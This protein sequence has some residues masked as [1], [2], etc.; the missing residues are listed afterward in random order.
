MTAFGTSPCRLL[1]E[2]QRSLQPRSAQRSSRLGQR[3]IDSP[4]AFRDLPKRRCSNSTGPAEHRGLAMLA[5]VDSSVRSRGL[6]K[7]LSHPVVHNAAHFPV[8]SSFLGTSELRIRIW[9]ITR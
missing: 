7:G 8:V 9:R 3:R 4:R 1:E 6:P 2:E 5:R